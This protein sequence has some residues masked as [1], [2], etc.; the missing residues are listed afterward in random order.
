MYLDIAICLI[1]ALSAFLGW[2]RGFMRGILGFTASIISL[3]AA[4][5]T[6]RPLA[7]LLD[8][9]FNLSEHLSSL[10]K[11]QG[12]FLNFL[13]CI[14]LIYA[15]IYLIF[16]FVHRAIRKV[17]EKN[18]RLD[19]VDKI[20][21]ILLGLAKGTLSICMALLA[22]YLLSSIPFM[23][24]AVDWMLNKST[25][26][27]FMYGITADIVAPIFGAIESAIKDRL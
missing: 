13:L 15:T 5:F 19:K 21:G 8:R 1:L 10:I 27:K 23:D 14:I 4:I 3:V 12:S 22:L 7:K 11:G 16:F 20:A 6:A 25:I 17:K 26:G 9:W 24:K 2:R 18:K